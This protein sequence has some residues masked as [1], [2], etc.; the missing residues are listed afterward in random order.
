MA[1]E[2]LRRAPRSAAL[3][4]NTLLV[5]T[6]CGDDDTDEEGPCTPLTEQG[7][8]SGQVCEEVMGG[9][10]AC[11]AP[12]VVKGRVLDMHSGDGISGAT[13]VALDVNNS[14]RSNVV[15]SGA[16][17]AYS[18]PVP[19]TRVVEDGGLVVDAI[20]LRVSAAG[21]HSFPT[22]PRE[23]LPIDL[24]DA[25][26]ENDGERVVMNASTDVGLAAI[27]GE[28]AAFG[29]LAGT[30]EHELGSGALVVAVQDEVAVSTA[31]A[32][33][34]GAFVLFN[35]PAGETT[36]EAYRAGLRVEPEAVTVASGA[37]I[38]GLTLAASTE[39]LAAVSGSVS[40]VNAEGGLT[41]SVILVLESTFS[42]NAAVV[43]GLGPAGLRVG[44]V[45]GAFRIEAVP[46]GKY[47]V[48]AAFENDRLVR[49]PDEGISGTDVVHIEVL[50]GGDDIAL[51]EGFK[52]TEALAIESP[53][54][55]GLEVLAA[56][57]VPKFV[58]ADDSSEDGYELRVFDSLGALVH[59]A[60]DIPRVSG[61]GRVEYTWNDAD[62]EPG[63][64]YQFRVWSWRAKSGAASRTYVS[65]SED[66]RGT[67]Q[68][69]SQQ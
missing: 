37:R 38:D 26:S 13:L 56:G 61:G 1:Y 35:V 8:D 42:Q 52:V 41:T 18:I 53:G 28:T 63:E 36:V 48:L 6:G 32:D 23:A 57:T 40:I 14:A 27:S 17:G 46:P 45:S 10:P 51:P 31:I 69:E 55:D 20:T 24:D 33:R 66:L 16:D 15:T 54:A 68:I 34:S 25:A 12:I 62:V 60:L 4:F 21:Y 47:A 5:L 50:D 58:W 39:P 22:P 65:A 11:F 2:R 3:L 49:D 67:F 9:E 44:D 64:I 43:R 19:V 59:E 30:V 7:C 29:S